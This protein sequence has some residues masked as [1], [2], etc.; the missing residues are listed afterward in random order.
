MFEIRN[1][2]KIISDENTVIIYVNRRDGSEV[3]TYISLED[4]DRVNKIDTT[5]CISLEG[6]KKRW[7]V[8]YTE[9]LGKINGKYKNKTHYMH[10]ILFDNLKTTDRV[11]H[12]NHNTLDNRRENL[13]VTTDLQ[14]EKNRTAKDKN[15][16]SGY[17]SVSWNGVS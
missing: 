15:N 3:E 6:N 7:Y 8:R 14:N 11:D 13:R 12:I 5:Y 2:Y 17:R 1:K 9:H 10:R 16:T 4:F